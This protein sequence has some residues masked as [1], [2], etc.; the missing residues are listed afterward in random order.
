MHGGAGDDVVVVVNLGNRAWESYRIGMPAV[1]QWRLRVNSDA[2][3]YS[4]EFGD[5]DAFDVVSEDI[6]QDGMPASAVVNLA[7]YTALVY[8]RAS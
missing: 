2:T 4:D 6:A 5:A 1:G 7:P 8:T 3:I